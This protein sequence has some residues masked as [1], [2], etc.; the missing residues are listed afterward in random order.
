MPLW[1]IEKIKLNSQ[2]FLKLLPFTIDIKSNSEII[3]DFKMLK[4]LYVRKNYI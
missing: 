3:L 2:R 1:Y 4:F